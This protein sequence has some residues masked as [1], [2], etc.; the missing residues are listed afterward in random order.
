MPAIAYEKAL[1]ANQEAV[2]RE[3]GDAALIRTTARIHRNLGSAY[4]E[5]GRSDEALDHYRQALRIDTERL[6]AAPRDMRTRMELSWNYIEI[7]WIQ[8]ERHSDREAE[9]SFAQALGLQQ[10]LAAADPQ[11][12]LARLEI[13]KLKLTASPASESAGNGK[14]A[15][16]YLLDA[17]A[18][19]QE[20]L[21]RDPSNDDARFHLGWAW[22][23]LGD[24]YV[25]AAGRGNSGWKRASDCFERAAKALEVL[26]LDG[27]PQG[28]LDP[29]PLMAHVSSRAK[30]CRGHLN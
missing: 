1:A 18:I 4:H 9:Q 14:R 2:A 17:T 23:N 16:Q 11:N 10:E 28:G 29:R 22:S 15:I 24:I 30:E 25:R 21:A 12:S 8:H 27:R 19:F 20:T 13:G 26:K 3:P 7:G 6:A 5:S